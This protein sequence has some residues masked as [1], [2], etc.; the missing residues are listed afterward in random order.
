MQKS[1]FIAQNLDVFE[2]ITNSIEI[3][4][5]LKEFL[6]NYR[7]VYHVFVRP[8]IMTHFDIRPDLALNSV[9]LIIRH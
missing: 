1:E 4:V 9:F 6:L 7:E 3:V 8:L 5:A 2:P